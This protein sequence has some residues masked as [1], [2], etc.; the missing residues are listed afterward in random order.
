MLNGKTGGGQHYPVVIDADFIMKITQ[1]TSPG[2]VFPIILSLKARK[3]DA[4]E[5]QWTV[6]KADGTIL[7]FTGRE[8]TINYTEYKISAGSQ[9]TIKL[10][11]LAPDPEGNMCK[12]AAAFIL[13]ESIFGNNYNGEE[14]DSHTTA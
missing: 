5:Y 11:V 13:T 6:T 2:P 9:L 4:T 7:S 12:E 14:F 8:V 3:P 1:N 10:T